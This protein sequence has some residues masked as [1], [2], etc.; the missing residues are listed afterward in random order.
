MFHFNVLDEDVNIE[1][2][3]GY[4]AVAATCLAPGYRTLLLYDEKGMRKGDYQFATLFLRIS[5]RVN[6][7]SKKSAFHS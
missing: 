2:F 3:V 4:S 1:E 5:S 7:S 6:V